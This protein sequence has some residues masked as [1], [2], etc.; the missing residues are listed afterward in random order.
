MVERFF[1]A[2]PQAYEAFLQAF[3]GP[4]SALHPVWPPSGE[5]AA[6]CSQWEPLTAD[7]S[8]L[9]VPVE[10]VD[11]RANRPEA[12]AAIGFAYVLVGSRQGAVQLQR[13][14][15]GAWPEAPR[16]FLGPDGATESWECLLAWFSKA[17]LT[18]IERAS[19]L[20]GADRCFAW[21]TEGFDRALAVTS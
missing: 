9:G 1:P 5:L 21:V 7:L 3:L 18:P 13:H 20:D 4:W 17:A 16:R 15:E 19:L 2:A 14:V 12:F 11:R 6:V 8:E 10:G